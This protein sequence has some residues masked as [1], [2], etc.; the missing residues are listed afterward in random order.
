[1]DW[2]ISTDEPWRSMKDTPKPEICPHCGREL[3]YYGGIILSKPAWLFVE[4]CDCEGA[5]A[6]R[7][8]KKR[9]KQREEER[10]AAY[11]RKQKAQ[12]LYA[13]S[14]LSDIQ[15]KMTFTSYKPQNADQD[16]AKK[17]M[18]NFV[19][20]FDDDRED[21]KTSMLLAGAY[22]LGK[23]HLAC[24]VANNLIQ[25]GK[26]VVFGTPSQLIN[27]VQDSYNRVEA[28]EMT[29][30][31]VMDKFTKADLLIIDDLGK[32]RV[33][34]FGIGRIYEIVDGR[35][36]QG[37]PMLITTNESSTAL[38]KR[39]TPKDGDSMTAGAIIDRLFEVADIFQLTGRSYRQ[40]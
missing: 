5:I 9:E 20:R 13:E 27:A 35:Y 38:V 11:E 4:Q 18:M 29:T 7:E 26:K 10:R 32:D 1:M 2:L 28:W 16:K 15:R 8:E 33:T 34:E 22:G 36:S 19:M 30:R 21:R 25:Q 6:E 40:K 39:L 3:P 37:L 31:Q 24:A 12:R 23:T 14:G 17:A